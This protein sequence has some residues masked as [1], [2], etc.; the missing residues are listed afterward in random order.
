L[1]ELYNNT[2]SN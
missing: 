2:E 1:H